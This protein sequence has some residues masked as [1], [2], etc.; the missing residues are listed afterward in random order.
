MS[1]RPPRLAGAVRRP[2]SPWLTLAPLLA[3]AGLLVGRL[4]LVPLDLTGRVAGGALTLSAVL[5]ASLAVQAHQERA[6]LDPAIVLAVGLGA[7]ALAL[8]AGGWPAPAPYSSWALPLALLA[9]VAEE[10]LVRRAAYGALA[11]YGAAVAIV[12]TALAFALV[13]VPLYGV[14][15]FPV[16]LGAGLVLSWQRWASGSWTVPA[17][18][19]AA[20]N[21]MMTVMR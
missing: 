7:L 11:P 16:D 13:H 18:T 2:R 1:A 3:A 6:R 9:A 14:A 21:L 12:V 17:T 20:A 5:V 4:W 15:V 8:A 19:H 10:A